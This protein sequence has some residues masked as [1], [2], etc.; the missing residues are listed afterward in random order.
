MD[1]NSVG[2]K[3]EG[4]HIYPFQML[5]IA[6]LHEGFVYVEVS[7][8]HNAICLR[9]TR[10]DLDVMDAIFLGQV[11]CHNHKHGAN[12]SNNLGHS[13]PTAKDIFEYEIPES[14]LVF[15]LERVP[16]RPG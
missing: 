9:V 6:R 14:L 5:V 10:G 2:P 1:S 16:L 8:F 13:T 3:D 12:I 4:C 7:A 15:L 11:T